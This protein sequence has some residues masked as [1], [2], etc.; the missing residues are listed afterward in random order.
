MRDPEEIC[1]KAMWFSW[2]WLA[3]G[4]KIEYNVTFMNG[5]KIQFNALNKL[6]VISGYAFGFLVKGFEYL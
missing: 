5:L 3:I 4:A 2:W 1:F 6:D